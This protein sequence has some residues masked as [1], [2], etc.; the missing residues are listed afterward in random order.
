MPDS[1]HVEELIALYV[2]GGLEKEE[3]GQVTAHLVSCAACRRLASEALATLALLPYAV[4]PTPPPPETKARLMARA[5]GEPLPV[6]L[7]PRPPGFFGRLVLAWR[8]LAPAVAALGLILV[9]VLVGLNLSL[10]RQIAQLRQE[11]TQLAQRLQEEAQHLAQS[12]DENRNLTER[13]QQ[14]EQYLAL[15]AGPGIV[16]RDLRGTDLAPQASGRLYFRPGETTG[17]LLVYDLSGLAPDETYQFWVIGPEGPQSAGLF[18]VQPD[19]R[20]ELP[21]TLPAPVD[22]YQAVGVSREPAEGSPQPTR[23]VLMGELSP[24]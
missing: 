14:Q 15:I 9:L 20:A 8:V 4:P 5:R 16:S 22:R 23:I 17:L 1:E 6:A 21:I 10:L 19:G 7:T 12:I 11:N 13:L 2:L 24:P 3:A 18:R